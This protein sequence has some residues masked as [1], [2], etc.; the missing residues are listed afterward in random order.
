MYE[1]VTQCTAPFGREGTGGGSGTP[2]LNTNVNVVSPEV[3]RVATVGGVCPL[4]GW[5][6]YSESMLE[7]GV[8]GRG[9]EV[10]SGRCSYYWQPESALLWPD[11]NEILPLLTSNTR[12][13]YLIYFTRPY[14]C[15]RGV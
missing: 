13:Q 12:G 3:F 6:L 5:D 7:L 11:E 8:R 2:W 1:N 4:T 10:R 9:V 14:S 15:F